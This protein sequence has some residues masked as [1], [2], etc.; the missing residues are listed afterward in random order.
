MQKMEFVIIMRKT[1]SSVM[2]MMLVKTIVILNDGDV[3]V[4]DKVVHDGD[5]E[6]DLGGDDGENGDVYK[7]DIYLKN[8][9]RYNRM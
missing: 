8:K 7:I 9:Y 4:S 2:M 6:V 5:E 3:H 1:S